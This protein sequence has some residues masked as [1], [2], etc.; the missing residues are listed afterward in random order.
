VTEQTV[1][2]A[3]HDINPIFE[4]DIIA[5]C[6]RFQDLGIDSYTLL[7]TP[8]YEMRKSNRL[9]SH[10]LF[11]GYISSL[12]QEIS[13]HGYAHKTKSGRADEFKK[14]PQERVVSR[15]RSGVSLLENSIGVRPFG[16]IPPMWDAPLRVVQ[17]VRDIGL[18]YCV[19]KNRIHALKKNIELETVDR[20]VSQGANN[21]DIGGVAL[22]L[23]LGGS[24]QLG[25]H[26]L[27]HRNERI[28]KL[29]TEM[30]DN[31]GYSFTGF[32]DYLQKA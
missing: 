25:I 31:L 9:D 28:F 29:I 3:L 30:K 4:D 7:I 16:F 12:G 20:L 18:D 15:L 2:L 10:D 21:V 19:I 24:F 1:L 23:E 8:A 11:S 14:M 27:D 17:A 22:E 5:T 6:D 13:L 32:Y 26:P